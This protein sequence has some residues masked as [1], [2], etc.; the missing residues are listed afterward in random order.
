M[1]QTTPPPFVP[2]PEVSLERQLDDLHLGE[3][4]KARARQAADELGTGDLPQLLD[5][6]LDRA[7]T[8]AD[9]VANAEAAGY[10]RGRNDK[11]EALTRP[12]VPRDEDQPSTP[13]FPIY[14]R[15]SI[16]D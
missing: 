5:A 1:E 2:Q 3:A 12:A 13:V 11:I 8:H 7:A 14:R 9:E 16:W 4:V 6:L 10:L 15:R